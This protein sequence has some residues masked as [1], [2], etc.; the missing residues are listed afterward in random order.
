MKILLS[1][2]K[3]INTDFTVPTFN[4]S[5]PQF[6]GESLYLVN[7]LSKFSVKK[8]EKL[9]DVNS[10]IA[11]LNVDRYA[12]FKLGNRPEEQIKPAVFIFTGEVYRGL[13]IASLDEKYYEKAQKSLRIL[14]G[15]YGLL[16]PF[17]LIYPYRLEMGTSWAVTPKKKNLYQFWSDKLALALKSEMQSDEIIVNLASNEYFKAIQKKIIAQRIITPTFK[18]YK[19]G[20]YAAVMMFAK[21]ARGKMARFL[22]ENELDSIEDLKHYQLDGYR[23]HKELS[24]ENEWVFTR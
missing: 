24:S 3:S 14:S 18:E 1:P 11:A 20:K 12:Q 5:E 19:N 15:L 10:A 7:K 22:I 23:F 16:K 6:A 2:A 13:D 21:H 17:D 8:I 9:M 4:F